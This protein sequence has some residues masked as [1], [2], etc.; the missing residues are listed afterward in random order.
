MRPCAGFERE[1]HQKKVNTSLFPVP[2]LRHDWRKNENPRGTPTEISKT[3]SR[4]TNVRVNSVSL[5]E[6]TREVAVGIGPL[7]ERVSII[8]VRHY[9]CH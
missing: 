2:L 6:K 1:S 8:L 7:L 9:R 5:L 4:A 3:S